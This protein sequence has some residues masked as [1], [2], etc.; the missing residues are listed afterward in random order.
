MKIYNKEKNSKLLKAFL[1]TSIIIGF[2]LIVTVFVTIFNVKLFLLSSPDFGFIIS[3]LIFVFSIICF[4]KFRKN[5]FAKIT[6]VLP[7]LSIILFLFFLLI[8]IVFGILNVV[9]GFEYSMIV[10]SNLLLALNQIFNFFEV[11]FASYL[12]YLFR[13]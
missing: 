6:L 13:K 4:L 3:F 1:Y 9:T 11:A 8:G 7:L 2:L 10:N 12:L 5:N